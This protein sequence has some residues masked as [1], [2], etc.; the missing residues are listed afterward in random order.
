MFVST[1]VC[2]RYV[3]CIFLYD[4]NSC[5]DWYVCLQGKAAETATNVFY[6][7][8][9]EGGVDWDALSDDTG[10]HPSNPLPIPT[11]PNQNLTETYLK[12]NWNLA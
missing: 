7:I 5:I 11:Q 8:T 2:G 3:V 4:S 10:T 9:Y 1:G 12:P 6:H